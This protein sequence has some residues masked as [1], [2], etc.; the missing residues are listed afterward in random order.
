MPLDSPEMATY[1][2][3]AGIC[4]FTYPALQALALPMPQG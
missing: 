3:G 2:K 1:K 4:T